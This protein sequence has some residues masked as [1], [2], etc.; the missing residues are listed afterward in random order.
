MNLQASF[1][2]YFKGIAVVFFTTYIFLVCTRNGE[3]SCPACTFPCVNYFLCL[4][5]V[6]KRIL[7]P[8][9]CV[10]QSEKER[11]SQAV[12]Q[13]EKQQ[14]TLCGDILITS[15]FVSY[16]GY[17]TRQYRMEL[18]N[19]AWIPFLRSQMVRPVLQKTFFVLCGLVIYRVKLFSL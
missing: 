12:V 1:Q 4:L 2:C 9:L 8:A 11:W 14:K 17:F 15:A 7:K 16:M 5:C 13:Y 6:F 10:F 18:L 3:G 19:N